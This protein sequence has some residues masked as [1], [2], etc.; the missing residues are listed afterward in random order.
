MLSIFIGPSRFPF[1]EL[2]LTICHRL[3]SICVR[4]NDQGVVEAHWKGA[5]EIILS[6]CSKFVNEHGEVQ[7]MTPE[8]VQRGSNI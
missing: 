2:D 1:V 6:L 5:A 3:V 4:Q 7:T 8:K